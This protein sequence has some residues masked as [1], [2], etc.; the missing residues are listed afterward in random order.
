M[1]TRPSLARQITVGLVVYG[2]LLTAAVFTHGLLVNEHAERRVWQAMLDS[3]MRDVL[4]RMQDDPDFAWRNNGRLDLHVL[5]APAGAQ[6]PVPARL[7]QLGPGLH[8]S[9]VFDG[10]EWV[11]LVRQAGGVRYAL[12]LDIDGF[13]AEEWELVKPVI[14]SSIAFMLLLGVA[15]YFG[16]RVFAR[17][18]RQLAERIATLAPDRRGQRI[19]VPARASSELV[20]IAGALNDYLERN[21]AFVDRE[22]AFLDTASHELRTPLAVIRSA[23]QV[24]LAAG[25]DSAAARQQLGRIARTTREVEEL[26]ALLLVLAREPDRGYAGAGRFRL[27]ELLPSIV[28]DHR[29][30]A[31]GKDLS[32]VIKPLPPCTLVAPEPVVRM[33]IGN[34]LRNAIEHSDR[35]EIRVGLDGRA[36]VI[37]DP[38]H[39]MTPE[40]ISALYAGMARE[41]HRSAGIGLAL[42]ARVSEHLGWM[43][44]IESDPGRGTTA[45]L[46]FNPAATA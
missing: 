12:A 41:G 32:L 27:D 4:D 6:A 43:L 38:G 28:D 23:T 22:R 7:R 15:V 33:A 34:L 39:G 13:E 36:V 9:V 31:D 45:R 29:H 26:I 14:A 42:I 11:V 5:D 18:L 20:V 1:S 3:E 19:A 25:P 21:D 37:Q 10:N 44:S 8:D 17:P 24:A 2:V 46:H 40:E 30:L 16:G 35:G